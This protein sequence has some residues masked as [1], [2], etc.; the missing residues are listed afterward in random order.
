MLTKKSLVAMIARYSISRGITNG[1]SRE[2]GI[3]PS[4]VIA[5]LVMIWVLALAIT[6]ESAIVPTVVLA[7]VE[8]L[9]LTVVEV[10]ATLS[11]ASGSRLTPTTTKTSL[12]NGFNWRSTVSLVN[13]FAAD[14]RTLLEITIVLLD[15]FSAIP[16]HEWR[17]PIILLPTLVLN[18]WAV[19]A[20]IWGVVPRI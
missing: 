19:L 14:S 15:Y 17:Y 13:V 18:I 2:N 20:W 8:M 3:P 6:F 10:P 16:Y 1:S 5:A 9:A 11:G 7:V 12:S 4:G